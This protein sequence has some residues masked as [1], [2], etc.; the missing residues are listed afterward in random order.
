M[1]SCQLFGGK[2]PKFF[3]EAKVQFLKKCRQVFLGSL[4]VNRA[5]QDE[6]IEE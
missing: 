1:I 5:S 6:R 2:L 3:Y 4:R